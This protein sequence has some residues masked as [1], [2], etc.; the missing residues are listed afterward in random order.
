VE[1]WCVER[2]A[3]RPMPAT[4]KKFS[5]CT[6][7]SA[8]KVPSFTASVS[9][10]GSA[11][12]CLPLWP[13]RTYGFE[14]LAEHDMPRLA[15]CLN[16]RIGA[17]DGTQFN[18]SLTAPCTLHVAL[19]APQGLCEG[20]GEVTQISAM[21]FDIC[22]LVGAVRRLRRGGICAEDRRMSN[23]TKNAAAPLKRSNETAF[24]DWA[25]LPSY[26]KGVPS[27]YACAGPEIA[28]AYDTVARIR[29]RTTP[30]PERP[31]PPSS[32]PSTAPKFESCA[33]V[34]GSPSLRGSGVGGPIDAHETVLRFNDHPFGSPWEADLGG[35]IDVHVL[36]SAANVHLAKPSHQHAIRNASLLVQL[37]CAGTAQHLVQV[38]RNDLS[39]LH[40]H[41]RSN[42][43]GEKLRIVAPSALLA[44]LQSY[45]HGNGVGG[46]GLV[47]VWLAVLL[48]KRPPKLF[49]F[50]T[51]GS[52]FSKGFV[53]YYRGAAGEPQAAKSLKSFVFIHLLYC[54]GLVSFGSDML[55]SLWGAVSG[56]L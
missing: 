28:E 18:L 46:T 56:M 16:V 39:A 45:G 36:Q 43:Y 32:G 33:V 31:A 52:N 21:T 34:G 19:H 3:A 26:W 54:L 27:D 10:I 37:R 22:T 4:P 13:P 42:H 25:P 17:N 38:L 8:A 2:R 47:G 30:H 29:G 11:G 49:G 15:A 14:E 41:A 50:S 20:Q 40:P 12:S 35:K 9:G 6:N 5:A 55:E 44:M 53:H 7:A 23:H 51:L 24:W 1:R 48:C